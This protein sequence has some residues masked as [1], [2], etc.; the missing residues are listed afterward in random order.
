MS[1][2][3]TIVSEILRL[4][5]GGEIPS[6]DELLTSDDP[7]SA[8]A[9]QGFKAPVEAAI[10]VATPVVEHA[11]DFGGNIDRYQAMV[12]AARHGDPQANEDL[13]NYTGA[14]AMGTVKFPEKPPI[15]KLESKPAAMA[16]TQAIAE[17]A[18]NA[19]ALYS[20]LEK[21]I[22]EK[23]PNTATR[24]QLEALLRDVK[25]EE[26]EWSGIDEFLGSKGKL[27]KVSKQEV[28]D[29]LGENKV[30]INEVVK[31]GEEAPDFIDEDWSNEFAE[32]AHKWEDY[33]PLDRHMQDWHL[34][35][36]LNLNQPDNFLQLAHRR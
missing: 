8:L 36:E 7:Q 3:K 1:D 31:G 19:P 32:D 9:A 29:H 14:L 18:P 17:E 20:K 2:K 11:L 10:N 4:A 22:Q 27:D 21:T 5:E 28:L 35:Q 23:L 16:A 15:V 26:R 25:G 12:T 30:Q 24:E 6:N 33:E 34:E 13:L